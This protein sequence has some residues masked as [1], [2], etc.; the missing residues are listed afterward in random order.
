VTATGWR[1]KVTLGPPTT[2]FSG[3]GNQPFDW[4]IQ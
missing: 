4:P 3:C 1:R 2:H